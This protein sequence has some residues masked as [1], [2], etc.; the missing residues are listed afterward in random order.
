MDRVKKEKGQLKKV[1]RSESEH[2]K[3]KSKTRQVILENRRFC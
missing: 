2:G 1:R 3:S